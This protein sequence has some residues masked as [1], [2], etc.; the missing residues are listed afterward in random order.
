MLICHGRGTKHPSNCMCE[1][2]YVLEWLQ[3][4]HITMFAVIVVAQGHGV[5]I[6]HSH[7]SLLC[8]DVQNFGHVEEGLYRSGQPNEFNFPFLEKL[9]L[10]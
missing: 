9:Q 2:A 7:L 3:C 8:M 5:S 1:H 10:K 4:I 6:N